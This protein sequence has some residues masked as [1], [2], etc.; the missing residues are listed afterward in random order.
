[1]IFGMWCIVWIV[2][3]RS[4]P[5]LIFPIVAIVIRAAYHR[6]LKVAT[7]PSLFVAACA[8][9][10]Y[11]VTPGQ[12]PADALLKSLT[13]FAFAALTTHLAVTY[14]GL[15][16][17]H[18]PLTVAMYL[19]QYPRCVRIVKERLDDF[20]YSMN[21]RARL[22]PGG[23]LQ[24][25]QIYGQAIVNFF[26]ELLRVDGQLQLIVRARGQFPHPKTF[27]DRTLAS[28]SDC[29]GDV[30]LLLI[31]LIFVSVGPD[32]AIPDPIL[33]WLQPIRNVLA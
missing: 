25:L 1:M 29:V 18:F 33:V 26:A 23:S 17:D 15:R 30:L 12:S 9:L 19:H 6:N 21:A 11:V 24:K 4:A 14:K 3:G 16:T 28:R 32:K 8:Y 22:M 27:E 7:G 13:L 10:A 5:A 31:A 20:M 2:M